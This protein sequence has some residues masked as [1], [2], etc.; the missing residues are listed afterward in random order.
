MTKKILVVGNRNL[1]STISKVIV[2]GTDAEIVETESLK[3]DTNNEQTDISM[4]FPKL[5]TTTYKVK[6]NGNHKRDYKYHK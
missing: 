1:T 3:H 4:L 5:T 2:N 6:I